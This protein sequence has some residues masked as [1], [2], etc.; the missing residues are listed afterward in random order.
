MAVN[1][2]IDKFWRDGYLI[3]RRLF[4]P[5]EFKIIR[6]Q[7]FASLEGRERRG[8]PLVDA[9]ADRHLKHWVYD[10]RLVAV[11]KAIL[12]SDR[13]AYFGDGG[14][15]VLGHKYEAGVDVG[16]WH[17][18]NTDRSNAD[19][20]DW[21]GR[22]SLIRFG[23]YLQDHRS[24]SGGLIVRRTS[25]NRI[26]KGLSA[27]WYDRY[28]NTGVGDVG[29]WSMRIQHAGLGRCIRYSPRLALGPY[30]QR[31]LPEFLQAPFPREERAGFWISYAHPDHH[32]ERHCQYLLTR[33]ERLDMW[34]HSHYTDD[35]LLQC[36]SAGLEVIDMPTRMRVALANGEKIGQH[37][38]HHSFGV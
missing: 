12:Q 19:A 11:G 5:S 31:K 30:L 37:K 24:Q 28:V 14:Y 36:Q 23:L 33:S 17:R 32:L 29:V 20:P 10:E 16:G 3:L 13:L 9:L 34:R 35:T 1:L 25:H 7:V 8:E 4:T 6:D 26:L 27:H 38:H 21:Q 22:Y 15:A 2:N 18:D